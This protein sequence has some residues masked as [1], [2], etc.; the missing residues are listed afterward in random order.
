MKNRIVV[1]LGGRVAE[2][3]YFNEITSGAS[4]D[5]QRAT[6]LA[7]TMVCELG[8]SEKMG[9]LTYG[10]R[11]HQAFLGRDLMRE[12]DYSEQTAVLIDEEVRRIIREAYEKT[13]QIISDN[14][15]KLNALSKELL[16]KEVLDEEEIK[17]IVGLDS[18]INKG[19]DK[20]IIPP[21]QPGI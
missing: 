7:Q 2:E 14:R 19:L 11:D 20:D 17:K 3:I 15:D 6:Q 13:R 4:D 8:M 18:I 5:L 9:N 21:I 16:E 10:K 12:K 1:L